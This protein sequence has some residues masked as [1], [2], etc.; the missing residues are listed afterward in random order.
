MKTELNGDGSTKDELA[1]EAIE[2]LESIG[3][4]FTKLSEIMN[5]SK[6]LQAIQE[7]IDRV[8]KNAISN[9]QKIQ[10]FAVLP[11]DFTIPTGELTPTMKLKRNF[12]INKYK[13]L[14]DSFY[15]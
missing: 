6:V 7:Y 3:L 4:S 14:I 10:K 12:V 8:N 2:W 13:D 11:N 9:A 1:A 15:A 5:D